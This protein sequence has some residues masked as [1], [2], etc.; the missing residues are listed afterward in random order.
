MTAAK[1]KVLTDHDEIRRW[2][3]ERNAKPAHVLGTG[4]DEDVGMLR[5]DFPGYSG[6]G[7]LEEITWDDFFNKFEEQ[8]LALIVQEQTAE[9]EPSNFNKLVSRHNEKLEGTGKQA[10][11][12]PAAK[13]PVAK[14]A[15]KP[16]AKATAKATTNPRAKVTAKAT[17]KATKKPSRPA[18]TKSTA[19]GNG[20][21]SGR[22]SSS[23]SSKRSGSRSGSA[24]R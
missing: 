6:E 19:R 12:K 24:T 5:L 1:T 11:R 3:E 9:G 22:V 10:T 16:M 20:A 4:G 18:P 15:A 8:E 17:A 2:A 13:Q 14:P 7:K 21:K 23:A